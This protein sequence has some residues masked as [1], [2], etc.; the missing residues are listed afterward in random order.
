MTATPSTTPK[1]RR[2]G[3]QFSL[4]LLLERPRPAILIGAGLAEIPS[5]QANPC[6]IGS[7]RRPI[8]LAESSRADRNSLDRCRRL[9]DATRS[10]DSCCRRNS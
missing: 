2:R 1:R 10:E 4:R 7:V 3:L 8:Y 5:V 6:E 9:L